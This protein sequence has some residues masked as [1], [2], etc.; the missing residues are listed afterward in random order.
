MSV[1]V[2]NRETCVRCGTCSRVCP[3]LMI[4]KDPDG[5][6]F[7]SEEDSPTCLQCGHCVIHCEKGAANLTFFASGDAQDLSAVR[8]PSEEEARR[9]LCTRRSVRRF[10]EKPLDR[11]AAEQVLDMARYAPSASNRQLVRWIA[12]TQK[13]TMTALKELY[14]AYLEQDASMITDPRY[15]RQGELLRRGLDPVFRGAPALLVAVLPGEYEWR[16]D[17]AIALE[18]AELSA[19]AL[20]IGACWAGFVTKALR[21][22]PKARELLGIAQGEW[23]S[24][25]LLMGYAFYQ[26]P[27]L[28]PCRKAPAV[29]FK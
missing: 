18:Y 6:P 13:S 22:D 24:G 20:G 3:R 23:V 1:F 7:V 16:E 9:L 4:Q 19:Y 26:P 17:G 28:L 29:E 8:I 5:Y 11:A 10:L 15:A 21:R 27:A 25:A 2:V 14:L 12:V